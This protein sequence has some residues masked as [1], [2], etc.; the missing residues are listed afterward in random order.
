MKSNINKLRFPYL[1]ILALLS[2]VLFSLLE[3]PYFLKFIPASINLNIISGYSS[4]FLV[5][6][7]L[8]FI[9]SY[10]RFQRKAKFHNQSIENLVL[11]NKKIQLQ[12][13]SLNKKAFT[14]S[15]HA[16]KLKYFISEKLLDFIEYDE[17]YLHFKSIASEVRHN[18]VI[19]YDKVKTFIQ[20]L[21]NQ[22]S[23]LN[24]HNTELEIEVIKQSSDDALI[25]IQYLWDL[26]DLATTDNIALHISDFLCD[27]EEHYI[28]QSLNAQNSEFNDFCYQPKTAL[29]DYLSTLSESPDEFSSIRKS[30]KNTIGYSNDQFHLIIHK[31]EELL[32][33]PNHFILLIE[34]IIKNAQFF[35]QKTKFKQKSD[36]ILIEIKQDNQQLYLNIYNRGPNIKDEIKQDIFKLGF[37]TRK[38]KENHGKGLGLFFS[39][40]IV[41]GYEGNISAQNIK[42]PNHRF[43]IDL[44]FQDQSTQHFFLIHSNPN[45]ILQVNI[46]E[47]TTHTQCKN[48]TAKSEF[49]QPLRRARITNIK[50]KQYKEFSFDEQNSIQHLDDFSNIALFNIDFVNKKRGCLIKWTALDIAGVQFQVTLPLASARLNEFDDSDM[51]FEDEFESLDQQF[52]QDLD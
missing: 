38:V 39:Q 49:E 42:N 36:R 26:L 3:N 52:K 28:Q 6:G 23:A 12:N 48:R 8:L 2:I 20:T 4:I 51:E 45:N 43:K 17:K 7:I 9:W 37:S 40:E 32:G 34:N 29:L 46:N 14:Y 24:K 10:I 25:A 31:S 5:I 22:I 47:P 41:S 1:S 21:Q 30:K 11:Q 27:C 35:L 33:N 19:S 44:T 16:D 15:S 50:T 13:K 18:G